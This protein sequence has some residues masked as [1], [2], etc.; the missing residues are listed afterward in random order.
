MNSNIST[1]GPVEPG[2]SK[3]GR[4]RKICRSYV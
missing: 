2:V 3:G 1:L 4:H